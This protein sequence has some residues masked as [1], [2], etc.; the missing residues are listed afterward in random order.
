MKLRISYLSAVWG[1]M[2]GLLLIQVG[3]QNSSR[4]PVSLGESSGLLRLIANGPVDGVVKIPAKRY[5]LGKTLVIANR[6]NLTIRAE[7]GTEILLEDV[8]SAVLEIE[9][10]SNIRFEGALLRHVKP[11]KEYQCH[12]EVVV[13]RNSSGITIENCDLN[14]CGAIGVSIADAKDVS[15]SNC[16]IHE[17]TFNAVYASKCDGLKVYDCVIERNGNFLQAHDLNGVEMSGNIIRDNGGYWRKPEPA[18]LR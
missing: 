8:N 13:I 2:I 17:N 7:P 1:L 14:G 5:V 11:L 4:H 12:G 16:W 6:Q 18:G 15:I 10:S 3:C 9:N